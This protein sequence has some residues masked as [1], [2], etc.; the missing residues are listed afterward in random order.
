[1]EAV[2]VPASYAIVFRDRVTGD[3][4]GCCGKHD[5]EEAN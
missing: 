2:K 4:F 1:M 5:R 3:M